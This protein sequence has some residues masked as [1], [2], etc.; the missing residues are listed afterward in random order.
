[1]QCTTWDVGRGVIVLMYYFRLCGSVC[2]VARILAYGGLE[3]VT[4]QFAGK[5][6]LVH[7]QAGLLLVGAQQPNPESVAKCACFA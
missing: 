6:P 3:Y 4:E 1:M 5:Q 2:T 7:Y